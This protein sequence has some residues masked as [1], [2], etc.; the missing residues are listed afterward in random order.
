MS[1]NKEIAKTACLF[2]FILSAGC[3]VPEMKIDASLA[4]RYA[5]IEPDYTG[6]VIPPNIAPLNFSVKEPGQEYFIRI[7]SVKGDP[8]RFHNSTGTIQIPLDAWKRLLAENCGQRMITDIFVRQQSGHWI[9]FDSMVNQISTDSIDGY[10]T[11]RKFG[12]LYNQFKKMGIYQRNLESFTEKPVLVNNLTQDNCMNCHNFYQNKT[13][14]WLLHLRGEPGT[15]M[16]LVTDGKVKK[17]DLKTKFNGPAAYPA[18]HPSGDV[19]AF[20]VS[21]LLLFFHATGNCR[22]V[23]DRASDIM[24]YDIPTNT[25]TTTPEIS[26]PE[27]MEIWPAWSL[28]GR[29]LYFCS[30]PKIETFEMKDKS[31]ELAYDKIRY[32]LMR[33]GYDPVQRTWGTLETVISA[34][35]IGLS[36]TEPRVSPDGKFL[37]FTGTAYSQFPIYLQ[38]ADV[39]L[40]DIGTGKWKKLEV[41]SD[42]PDSFHSWS[43]NGRWI[44]FSSKRQDNVFTRPYFSHIDSLGNASKP[45]LLPQEDFLSQEYSL[46]VYNVPEFTKEPV[47]ISPQALADAAFSQQNEMITAKLDPN[48]IQNRNTEKAKSNAQVQIP[49]TKKQNKTLKAGKF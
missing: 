32:D 25:V 21:K 23:L 6:I 38:S 3:S 15:S 9:R 40:L 18:W 48:V 39:F 26:S 20:S 45:F 35:Q 13:E 31:G 10:L 27:R 7:Q 2:L 42:R 12:S 22:D 43:S 16:L 17:I 37:L 29:Y 30:A 19:I 11:Y 8:I 36:I 24:L 1:I 49:L 44:V 47:H 34:D 14:R 41:N 5:R 28:D 46:N 4:G 33:I